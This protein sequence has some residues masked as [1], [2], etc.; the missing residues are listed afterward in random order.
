MDQHLSFQASCVDA[1]IQVLPKLKALHGTSTLANRPNN[2]I[3]S[4]VCYQEGIRL[5]EFAPNTWHWSL[6]SVIR[7]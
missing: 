4:V 7:I 3:G 6:V 2:T 1:S 5:E